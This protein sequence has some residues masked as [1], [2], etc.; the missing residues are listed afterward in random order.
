MFEIKSV[1]LGFGSSPGLT[2]AK[3]SCET[4]IDGWIE[5]WRPSVMPTTFR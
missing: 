1:G 3:V 2:S 5:Y 4:I